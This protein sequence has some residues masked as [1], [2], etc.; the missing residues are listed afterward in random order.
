MLIELYDGKHPFRHI[1]WTS[2]FRIL[3]T[4]ETIDI[5]FPTPSQCP[6]ELIELMRH[7]TLMNPEQR[8]TFPEIVA[9]MATIEKRFVSL[10]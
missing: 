10:M 1:E 9:D 6:L 4:A 8:P 5:N 7:C 2:Q 3:M